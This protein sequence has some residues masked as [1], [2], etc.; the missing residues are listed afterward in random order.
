MRFSNEVVRAAAE[1]ESPE[2]TKL[3]EFEAVL[4]ATVKRYSSDC[5]DLDMHNV[6]D[7]NDA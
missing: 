7:G 1:E 4:A 2:L 5:G 6:G 3:F